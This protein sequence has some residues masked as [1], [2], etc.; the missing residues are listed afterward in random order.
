M[1]A[2]EMKSH[3]DEI[4]REAFPDTLQPWPTFQARL[5]ASDGKPTKRGFM[6]KTQTNSTKLFPP[7][8]RIAVIIVLSL[9]FVGAL[10]LITPQGSVLAQNI[11]KF[12][13]R[14]RSNTLLVPTQAPVAW[15]EVTPGMTSVA[16]SPQ[17]TLSGAVFSDVCG[18][19]RIPRCSVEQ[20]RG[21][22]NFT[23]KELGI[24]PSGMYFV[25]ATGGP[26]Q[27]IL[28]YD[29]QDHSTVILLTEKPWTGSGARAAL[30]ND[31][32]PNA[33]IEPV[34][35]GANTGEYV[36]G[37]FRYLSGEK[38]A[39]W[40]DNAGMQ[41]LRWID[42]GVFIAMQQMGPDG[43]FDRAGMV[44]LAESLTTDQV[45]AKLTPM[46]TMTPTMIPPAPEPGNQF[47]LG[48]EESNQKAGFTARVPTHLPE[49][50]KIDGYSYDPKTHLVRINIIYDDPSIPQGAFGMVISEELIPTD[51]STCWLC[52]F[53]I[54]PLS[55]V[56]HD[57][58]SDYRTVGSI[59][60]VKIGT[61]AGQYS[62]GNWQN[63]QDC[64]GWTWNTD[65]YQSRL[66]WQD[67][68]I[69]F[70]ISNLGN[71]DTITKDVLVA[72]AESMK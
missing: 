14:S 38:Q 65:P 55:T 15:I 9:L 64:C 52:G 26:D 56:N 68:G 13:T 48:M 39:T 46:P 19:Y 49:T 4:A 2:Q 60:V 66:R 36:K 59:E 29:T 18:D 12:F 40:N 67:K 53:I 54:G 50:Y 70:E 47:I 43:F 6:M 30:W 3:L 16:P 62:A 51:P 24:I 34:Q 11:I 58:P 22:V 57:T 71:A 8:A 32:S 31:V 44:A 25:G 41:D 20:I 27:V 42:N 45:I 7:V 35:I 72:I 1:K 23:I 5:Q 21:K 28:L 17:P 69:A 33:V 63:Y 10:F 61:F 37:S